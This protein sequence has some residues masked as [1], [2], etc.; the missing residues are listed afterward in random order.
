MKWCKFEYI[1]EKDD[2]KFTFKDKEIF[3]GKV[4]APEVFKLE[5]DENNDIIYIQN[6]RFKNLPFKDGMGKI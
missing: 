1:D 3:N 6:K 2:F 4:N 5:F